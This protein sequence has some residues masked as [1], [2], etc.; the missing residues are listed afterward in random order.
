VHDPR[1][2]I[3]GIDRL[4]GSSAFARLLDEL[5]RDLVVERLKLEIDSL[6]TGLGSGAV[7]LPADGDPAWYAER[8]RRSAERLT[9]GSLRPVLNATGVIL[10]T[11]LGRAPLAAAALDAI[12]DVAGYATLEYDTTTGSRGSRYEHCRELLAHL[13]GAEDAVVVNNNAAALVLALNTVA[14]GRD[15]VISRGEL[16]EIGGAFRVPDI[17]ARSGARLREVG[18]TNRTHVADYRAALSAQ[19]GAILKVH[20]S[21]FTMDGYIAEASVAELAGI[22]AESGVPLVHDI[23]SGLLADPAALGLADEPTPSASLRQGADVVTFSGDKL[24]GGP[25]CGVIAGTAQL[26]ERMRRN[27]LCR[28]LR[29]DK[30]TLAALAATLRLYLEPARALAEIPVLRMLRLGPA[31]LEPRAQACASRLQGAGIE[32][33]VSDGRSTVGGGASPGAALPTRLVRLTPTLPAAALERRLRQ[34][35][36]P[37]IARIVD[38]GLTLD[39]RTIDP[40]EDSALCAAVVAAAGEAAR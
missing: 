9:A 4:L 1:R 32:C 14:H 22:A 30:L 24:L 6:R 23:G 37:V 3:P 27:P 26:V 2:A 35:R 10:H 12:R 7:E 8:V 40:A 13:T 5:P 31:E 20:P 19:T 34:A 28:A 25:Q 33:T 11:N 15:A 38:D 36:R 17:M 29:V 39:L 16:V 21:N 18:A